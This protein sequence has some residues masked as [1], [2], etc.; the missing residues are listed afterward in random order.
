MKKT[1]TAL[2]ALVALLLAALAAL[3]GTDVL[4]PPEAGAP[5]LGAPGPASGIEAELRP[6]RITPQ[7]LAAA[8]AATDSSGLSGVPLLTI[9]QE[10]AARGIMSWGCGDDPLQATWDA[11][12]NGLPAEMYRYRYTV[13]GFAAGESLPVPI[14]VGADSASITVAGVDSLGRTGQWCEPAIW[15]D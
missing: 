4:A 15:E 13:E 6:A 3:L 10:L 2:G 11:P 8:K 7:M 14:A 1:G 9:V 12:V 5:D